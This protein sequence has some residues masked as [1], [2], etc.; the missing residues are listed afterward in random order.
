[1]LR[2]IKMKWHYRPLSQ[3][4]IFEIWN[5]VAIIML[6]LEFINELPTS[7]KLQISILKKYYF[8]ARVKNMML[9]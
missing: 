7:A 5:T 8:T 3:I 6:L 1:M 4:Y 2:R 9:L